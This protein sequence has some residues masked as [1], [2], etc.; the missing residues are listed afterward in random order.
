MWRT[1]FGLQVSF[2]SVSSSRE[3]LLTHRT[4]DRKAVSYRAFNDWRAF[5]A[6]L[7][8]KADTHPASLRDH[9]H[10]SPAIFDAAQ[11]VMDVVAPWSNSHDP[12][13]LKGAQNQLCIIFDEAVR[14]A[15][16]L[17]RQ[18]ALWSIRFPSRKK[19]PNGSE[20]APL[21]FDAGCMKD[22]FGDDEDVRPEEL[23]N[24]YVDLVVSP[25][26]WKRGTM[27]GERFESEE[28]AVPAKVVLAKSL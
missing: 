12:K 19:L 18:R 25:V 21:T 24:C 23:G 6:E 7:L 27:D 10:A 17:R 4:A 8:T 16:F 2:S 28:A 5:T 15:Q 26:L 3:T 20:M 13:T 9:P 22:E 11:H 14:F 1:G